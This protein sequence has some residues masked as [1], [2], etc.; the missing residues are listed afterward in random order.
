[1][2]RRV[3]TINGAAWTLARYCATCGAPVWEPM[4]GD[5]PPRSSCSH[6]TTATPDPTPLPLIADPVPDPADDGFT[7]RETAD[8]ADE[9]GD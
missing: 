2:L 7:R 1:M 5:D 8:D 4:Q 6:T 9:D 3:S